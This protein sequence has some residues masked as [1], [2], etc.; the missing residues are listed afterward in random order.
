MPPFCRLRKK[1]AGPPSPAVVLGALYNAVFLDQLDQDT[2]QI[3]RINQLLGKLQ[4]QDRQGLREVNTVVIRPS[5]DVG[6]LAN[7]YEK[8]LPRAIRYFM[9]RFGSQ[10]AEEQDLIST[11]MF[12]REYIEELLRLGERDAADHADEVAKLL[13]K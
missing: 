7:A 8:L 4:P 3:D 2:E 12:H 6:A 13:A 1:T 9:R 10:E 11:I 5:E